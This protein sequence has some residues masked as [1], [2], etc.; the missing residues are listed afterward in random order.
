[1]DINQAIAIVLFLFI[2]LFDITNT[3]IGNNIFLRV[4]NVRIHQFCFLRIIC[5]LVSLNRT[6]KVSFFVKINSFSIIFFYLNRN[7]LFTFKRNKEKIRKKRCGFVDLEF[8]KTC[9]EHVKS[10]LQHRLLSMFRFSIQNKQPYKRMY[11]AGLVFRNT[12]IIH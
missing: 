11:L 4:P 5:I 12:Y 7:I 1:M 6:C 9:H 10:L 3:T 2:C 8:V